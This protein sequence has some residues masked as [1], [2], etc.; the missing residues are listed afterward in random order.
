VS[1][2]KP[3]QVIVDYVEAYK[4]SMIPEDQTWNIRQKQQVN[5]T[6]LSPSPGWTVL[7]SDGA[8]KTSDRKTG[9]GGVLRNDKGLWLAGFAKA[10]GHTTT[11][12]AELWGVYEGL[13]L[14]NRRGVT[15]LELRTDS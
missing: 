6:W 13:R 8:A 9:C 3:W 11:Y 10:L 15:G 1:P 7:N 14:A 12:M 2:E 4:A 5:V